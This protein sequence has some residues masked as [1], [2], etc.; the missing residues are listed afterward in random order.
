[1]DSRFFVNEVIYDGMEGT[2]TSVILSLPKNKTTEEKM[3][4]MCQ[5][6]K[7][8]SKPRFNQKIEFELWISYDNGVQERIYGV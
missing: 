6:L 1:M 7:N 2:S 3:R 8:E 5:Q 4:S